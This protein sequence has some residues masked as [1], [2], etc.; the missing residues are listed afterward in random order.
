ME[1]NVNAT[2]GNFAI[3]TSV[4]KM[5]KS[6]WINEINCDGANFNFD[7][8]DI[9]HQLYEGVLL[10]S[11]LNEKISPEIDKEERQVMMEELRPQL[12]KI[13]ELYETH[14]ELFNGLDR[15]KLRLN[16]FREKK[17][18]GSNKSDQELDEIF[19]ANAELKDRS[20]YYNSSLYKEV[21]FLDNNFHEKIYDFCVYSLDMMDNSFSGYDKNEENFMNVYHESFFNMGII[22]HIHRNFNKVLF[23]SITE[24][25]LFKALNLQNIYPILKIIDKQ[26]TLYLFSELR[27]ILPKPVG[28][29]WISG[30]LKELNVSKKY[31]QSKYRTIKG[32]SATDEQKKFAGELDT[33]FKDNI[34][35]LVS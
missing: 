20:I 11:W 15:R 24:L 29:K 12:V 26:R 10:P 14:R 33:L 17:F 4:F 22:H 9:Y 21:G 8:Q 30:I 31:Y 18:R 3:L 7:S 1:I 23:E 25:Q 19:I 2:D 16:E 32:G 13:I 34:K 28:D 6:T 5:L 27:L 35:P